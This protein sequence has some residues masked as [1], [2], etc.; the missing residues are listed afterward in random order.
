MAD[1][2]NRAV[3]WTKGFLFLGLGL[4]ASVLLVLEAP[5]VKVLLLLLLSVWAFCRFYYFA[6][7]VIQ[8]G[9]DVSVFRSFLPFVLR[10]SQVAERTDRLTMGITHFV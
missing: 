10:G 5:S 9:L 1:I 7:Y 8:R 2:K 4:L 3:I 6:F